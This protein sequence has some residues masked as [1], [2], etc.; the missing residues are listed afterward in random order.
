MDIIISWDA[1]IDGELDDKGPPGGRGPAF[2]R[3][4]EYSNPVSPTL[5]R[6]L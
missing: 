4:Y 2:Q 5:E 3:K 6:S 1:R